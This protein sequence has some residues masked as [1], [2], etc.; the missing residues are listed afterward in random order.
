MNSSL[1]GAGAEYGLHSLLILAGRSDPASVR[2]L[3]SFQKI[4]ESFLAKLFT[5]MKRAGLVRGLEGIS[6]GFVLAIPAERIRVMD[7]LAAVDPDRTLFA[8]DEIR[9]QCALYGPEPPEWATS[10]RCR[11]HAFMIEA[12]QAL[13]AFLGSKTLADLA[14]EYVSKAPNAFIEDTGAWFR[15]RKTSRTKAKVGRPTASKQQS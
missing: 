9:R 10:G 1:Y 14:G 2:D 13:H 4:P 12:E 8:C 15:Q 5:R 7:V 11:I 6:G 3:A